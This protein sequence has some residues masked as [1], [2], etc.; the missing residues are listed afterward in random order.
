MAALA[1][2]PVPEPSGA[3]AKPRIL[4]PRDGRQLAFVEEAGRVVVEWEGR[5]DDRYVLEYEVGTGRYLM[6]GNFSVIG[7]RKAFG[8]LK[9]DVWNQL[10]FYNPFR[11]RIRPARCDKAACW[12]EWVTFRV[13]GS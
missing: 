13:A 7:P 2:R 4:R 6:R 1:S 3:P 12:S 11:V 5:P 10:V 8:P 9:A